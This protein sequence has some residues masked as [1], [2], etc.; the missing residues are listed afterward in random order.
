MTHGLRC[1]AIKQDPN[2]AIP[3]IANC[4]ARDGCRAN[5]QRIWCGNY[6]C[7]P[8]VGIATNRHLM[9]F[10]ISGTQD[11][12][13]TMGGANPDFEK[14]LPVG[15]RGNH[16]LQQDTRQTPGM[17]IRPSMTGKSAR[18]VM[19][20]AQVIKRMYPTSPPADNASAT[21]KHQISK[22]LFAAQS[23]IEALTGDLPATRHRNCRFR[24]SKRIQ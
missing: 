9:K 17:N 7:G 22:E 21:Q 13:G 11:R 15:A 16:R 14:R 6:H 19:V 8:A 1:L 3:S 23:E 10:T 24:Y 2:S 4:R 12:Y 20:G 5:L 18:I